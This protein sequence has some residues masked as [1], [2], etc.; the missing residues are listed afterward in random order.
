MRER[1][2]ERGG[3]LRKKE[4]SNSLIVPNSY[5]PSN[6]YEQGVNGFYPSTVRSFGEILESP[7][8]KVVPVHIPT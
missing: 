3:W 8:K 2:R 7:G 1:E 5:I 6:G 4:E